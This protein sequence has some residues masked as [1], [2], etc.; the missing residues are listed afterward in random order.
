[1]ELKGI[2]FHVHPQSAAALA[3]AGQERREVLQGY[4][5]REMREVSYEELADQYRKRQM[6][7]VLLPWD[8]ETTTGYPPVPNDEVAAAVKRHPDVF[9]GFAGV[10]PWKGKLAL[11]EVR[12]AHDDLGLR[13]LKFN[14]GRNLFA[15]NDPHFYPLWQL[16]MDLGMICLFHTGMLGN[17]AGAPGGLGNKLKYTAPIPYLD[18][19]AADFPHLTIVAAHPSWP[20]QDEA[21]AMALHK[22]NVYLELSGWAPK[23]FPPQ[24][25]HYARTRLQDK[26]LFGTDWPVIDPERWLREFADLDF[27]PEVRQ[28]IMVDNARKVLGI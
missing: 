15:P 23:Y 7:A 10:D 19:I 13:G 27:S 8:D 9:I 22:G 28:K 21:L 18:D 6:M 11:N 20:W 16:A 12:R 2:D 25:V 5:G 24:L 1:V 4:F 26:C 14:P 17:G 3:A